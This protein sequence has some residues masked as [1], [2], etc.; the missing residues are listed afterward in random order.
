MKLFLLVLVV[1]A[2]VFVVT[3]CDL[4]WG[5]TPQTQ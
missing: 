1:L 3:G 5:V 2:V 4:I